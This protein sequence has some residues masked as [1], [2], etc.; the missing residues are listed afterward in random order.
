MLSLSQVKI[1]AV[2]AACLVG[3]PPA[4]AGAAE[5]I[6]WRQV[7]PE[8]LVFME[9]PEGR[10]T[11]ELNPRFAPQT[12]QQFRK[13][14]QDGFY[15]GLSFYRVIDGFVAQGGDGSDLGELS[16][17][18]LIKAEFEI[19]LAEDIPFTL[20]QKNDLFATET[21]FVEG[22]AAARDPAGN[23]TWLTHCPGAV[24]MARN[25]G[26]DSSRTDFYIVIGQAPR[27]LD[28]NMNLF[29]RVIEGMDVVQKIERGR[30]DENGI[31][32]DETKSSRVRSITLASD[33]PESERLTAFVMD[34]ESR[35]FKHM[36]ED[37][38]NRKQKF[39]HHKPPK[40]LDV[41]QVPMTGRVTK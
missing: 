1:R 36:L 41:C 38:R 33:I 23:K 16:L 31:I 14:V 22:F 29:G 13:L 24:A 12:V 30:A 32:A 5:D 28:R 11:L 7:Q 34:T 2:L 27:Y 6:I 19:E 40:V 18:P 39:F 15:R 4:V 9:L 37:R 10:V 20:V 21:G 17:V 26:A 3:L 8:N 25:D 35:G